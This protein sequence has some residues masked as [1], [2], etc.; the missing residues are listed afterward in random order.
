MAGQAARRRDT[1]ARLTDQGCPL[2]APMKSILRMSEAKQLALVSTYDP[3]D[4]KERK[5]LLDLHERMGL[6]LADCDCEIE[7]EPCPCGEPDCDCPLIKRVQPCPHS[8][9]V[10]PML[11]PAVCLAIA[12]RL[13]PD[14]YAEPAAPETR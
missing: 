9:D 2:G 5:T 11:P 4:P 13:F 3:Q 1:I 14:D 7:I 8:R 6:G 10:V 12:G